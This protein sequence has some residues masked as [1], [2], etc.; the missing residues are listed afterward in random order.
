M[1][2]LYQVW[3]GS[4][5]LSCSQQDQ[6]A[7]YKKTSLCSL[8]ANMAMVSVEVEVS[9]TAKIRSNALLIINSHINLLDLSI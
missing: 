4:N 5:P 9:D 1:V 2:S 8:S 3:I 6:A 7:A